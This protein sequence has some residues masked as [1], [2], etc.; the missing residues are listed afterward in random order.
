MTSP[1]ILPEREKSRPLI[2][3]EIERLIEILD[4]LDPE[5]DLEDTADEEPWLGM[6]ER[7]PGSWSGLYLEGN[8]DCEEDDCDREQSCEDEGA[9]CDD[10]GAYNDD[11]EPEDQ[12][13]T[14]YIGPVR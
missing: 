9:K 11:L 4:T 1:D 13:R 8:D 12:C 10:E 7:M 6:P 3:S 14:T 2:E 5:P